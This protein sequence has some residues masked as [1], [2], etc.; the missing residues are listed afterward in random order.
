MEIIQFL[1]MN[2]F[3]RN[4]FRIFNRNM[5]THHSYLIKWPKFFIYVQ[6]QIYHRIEVLMISK[7]LTKSFVVFFPELHHLTG[8]YFQKSSIKSVLKYYR[9]FNRPENQISSIPLTTQLLKLVYLNC[10]VDE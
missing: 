9:K 4:L 5:L 10:D 2:L 1:L 6:I 7:L 8:K 3:K